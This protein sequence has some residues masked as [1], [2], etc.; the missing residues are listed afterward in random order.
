MRDTRHLHTGCV[1]T[2]A[3]DCIVMRDTALVTVLSNILAMSK[4]LYTLHYD[5]GN[6]GLKYTKVARCK[7][8]A[9]IH[10]TKNS[11]EN[12]EYFCDLLTSG[13]H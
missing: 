3:L 10:F 8:R 13:S 2:N 1:E 9:M 7:W 5:T 12:N 4:R 11:A 6:H